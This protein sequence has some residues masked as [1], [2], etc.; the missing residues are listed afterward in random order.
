MFY[1]KKKYK[2]L[3][4]F[5]ILKR[6]MPRFIYH[7]GIYYNIDDIK[8]IFYDDG[9]LYIRFSKSDACIK[10]NQDE[11]IS[12]FLISERLSEIIDEINDENKK[13]VYYYDYEK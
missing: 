5:S 9:C 7:N 2:T 11:Y 12:T 1:Y 6:N 4:L 13:I 3:F 8:K 10:V